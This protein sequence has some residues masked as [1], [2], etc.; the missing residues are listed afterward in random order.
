[1]LIGAQF[2]L[3]LTCIAVPVVLLRLQA[4]HPSPLVTGCVITAVA[5][6]GAVLTGMGSARARVKR[7]G[8]AETASELYGLDLFGSALG[9]VVVSVYAI[10]LFGLSGAS[11][12]AGVFWPGEE[13]SA[14]SSGRNMLQ[15]AKHRHQ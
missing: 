14:F 12:M 5:F 7:G 3:S 13:S 4:W 11:L 10:P 2:A 8:A 6:A 9:A 1:M 15:A